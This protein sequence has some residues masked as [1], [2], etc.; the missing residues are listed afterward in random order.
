MIRCARG[1]RGTSA[2]FA[3]LLAAVFPAQIS[4]A[5]APAALTEAAETLPEPG[6][7]LDVLHRVAD[8]QLAREPREGAVTDWVHAAFYTGVTALAEISPDAEKYLDALRAV[9]RRKRWRPGPRVYNADDHCI[10]Q[11]YLELHRRDRDP[12]MIRPSRERFDAILA[13]PRD[14]DLASG[15]PDAGDRWSWCDALFMAPPAWIRMYAAT[16]DRRYLDFMNRGWWN[17]SRY[18]YDSEEHLFFRDDR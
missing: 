8:R 11:S 5:A 10:V 9:G 18:L 16:N 2:L 3:G 7:I 17:T 12:A 6:E 4:T 14:D 15:R 13:Q 1:I